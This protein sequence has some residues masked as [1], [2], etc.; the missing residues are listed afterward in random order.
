MPR[1]PADAFL[2]LKGIDVLILTML[3]AGER[4]GYGIRQDI[5][6]H[7]DGALA[8][9]AGNLYRSIRRLMDL[10]FVAEADRRPAPDA[11]DERRRYYRISAA[12]Q[13]A[14]AAELLR[15]RALVRVAEVRGVIPPEPA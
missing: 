5:V 7:T 3:T 4:H 1:P 8:P 9:E 6:A 2:P 13:R 15:L 12:G 10:G 14:L 11:D